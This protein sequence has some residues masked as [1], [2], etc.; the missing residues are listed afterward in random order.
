MADDPVPKAIT[1][2]TPLDDVLH[3]VAVLSNPCEYK[4]RWRLALEFVARMEATPNVILYVAELA[5]GH[6]T[7][8]VTAADNARH[9]Q[10]RTDT[11]LWHKESCVMTIVRTLLPRTWKAFAWIDADVQFVTPGNWALDA[12][13]ILNGTADVIQLFSSI[14]DLDSD[15][16]PL[17]TFKSAAMLRLQRNTNIR[18]VWHPGYAWAMR[19]SFFDTSGGLFEHAILGSGDNLMFTA[20]TGFNNPLDVASSPGYLRS[21]EQYAG[22]CKGARVGYIP[23]VLCHHYHGSK[24]DRGYGHRWKLLV[25][26]GYDPEIHLARDA[27][28]LLVASAA[29]PQALANDIM[30]YFW[31]RN[32]DGP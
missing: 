20:W 13:R 1:D 15:G 29:F 28:G 4:R 14:V 31:S 25:K 26:Y 3:V 2:N 23:Y 30:R 16:K 21:Y 12:L 24:S 6:Q 11:P 19:R 17:S 7:Y 18:D 27:S 8:H 22:L 9:L 10:L 32:E 5:Y